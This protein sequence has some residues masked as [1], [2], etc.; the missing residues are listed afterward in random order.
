MTGYLLDTNVPSEFSR[1]QPEPRVVQWLET[2]AEESLF[3]SAVTIGEIRRGLAMLPDGQR[4]TRLEAW[5]HDDLIVWF[6]DRILPVTRP[7]AE[8]WGILDARSQLQGRQ[9]NTADGMIAATALEHGLTL[10][11]R[12]TRD[13]ESLNVDLV[14][15]WNS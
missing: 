10:V 3:L 1:A 7:I 6:Q 4:R 11:T 5:F 13:F 15:P 9:L 12:N 14:N 2:L 8:R